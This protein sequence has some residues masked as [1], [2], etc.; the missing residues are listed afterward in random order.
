MDVSF[1]F[2]CRVSTADRQIVAIPRLKQRVEVMLLC[3]RFDI[4]LAEILPDL[5]ILNSAAVEVKASS[6]LRDVLAVS[7]LLARESCLMI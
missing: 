4:L 5:G 3:R 7:H 2:Y 1:P 6:R